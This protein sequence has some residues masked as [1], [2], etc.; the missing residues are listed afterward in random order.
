MFDDEGRPIYGP[1]LSPRCEFILKEQIGQQ[2][3]YYRRQQ[4]LYKTHRPQT[5]E[6]PEGSPVKP[7]PSFPGTLDTDPGPWG[8]EV[9]PPVSCAIYKG[10]YWR[11]AR[12]GR[13]LFPRDS[14][15]GPG[16]VER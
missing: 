15:P 13:P 9:A 3:L 11:A 10:G 7:G 14:G 6:L 16:A 1:F 5:E 2:L 12:P 8:D 4:N